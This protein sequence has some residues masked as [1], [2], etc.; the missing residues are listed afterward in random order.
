MNILNALDIEGV[1]E[2]RTL[3]LQLKEAGTTILLS[4]HYAED[5]EILC[6]EVFQ[7]EKGTLT[8]FKKKN[9]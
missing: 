6:D 9:E 2:F 4:S 3:F 1:Q 7:M 8:I 5:I